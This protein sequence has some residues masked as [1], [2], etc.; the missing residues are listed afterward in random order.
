M[1]K[2]WIRLYPLRHGDRSYTVS[3]C[4]FLYSIPISLILMT[5]MMMMTTTMTTTAM[6]IMM[7]MI[8]TATTTTTT[9]TTTT[10]IIIIIIMMMMMLLMIMRVMI[11]VITVIMTLEFAVVDISFTISSLRGQLSPTCTPLDNS[12]L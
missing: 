3:D 5:V 10:I 6:I 12:A 9:T 1:G 2:Y 7:M 4:V 11:G 8:T